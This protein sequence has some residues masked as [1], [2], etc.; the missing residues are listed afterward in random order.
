MQAG[1]RNR[2]GSF[3]WPLGRLCRCWLGSGCEIHSAREEDI[4]ISLSL[5]LSLSLDYLELR[6]HPVELCLQVR[7]GL[8]RMCLA[9]IL[10]SQSASIF[11]IHSQWREYFLRKSL[12]LSLSQSLSLSLSLSLSQSL[13]LSL[14]SWYRRDGRSE[15]LTRTNP[16]TGT[17]TPCRF[18]STRYNE[19]IYY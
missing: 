10:E 15:N 9:D 12:S 18:T 7:L 5:S 8:E 11:T 16:D 1:M 17:R 3:H 4:L 14:R 19:L 6:Q 2:G 13:S